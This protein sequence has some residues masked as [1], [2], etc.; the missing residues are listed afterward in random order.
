PVNGSFSAG[1]AGSNTASFNIPCAL[2]ATFTFTPTI[3]FTPS[4]T[5]TSTATNTITNT[6]TITYTPTITPTPTIT[7]T[8]TNTATLTST[9]T[10]TNTAT[11]TNTPT[12][13]FT[14]TITNTPVPDTFYVSQNVLD[15]SQGPVSIF[16]SYAKFP[17]EY[18]L[19]VFNSAGE[20]IVDI[21]PTQQLIGPVAQS[22]SWDG[23]NRYHE[24]CASG[25]YVLYLLEPFNRKVKRLLLIR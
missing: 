13:T 21:V 18:S 5:A 15:E 12:I 22:Y 1:N 9:F 14:P 19:K 23:A 17:G 2:T 20:Y 6:S 10:P 3:T 7:S 25:V 8:K 11:I 16:V 4:S 24:K